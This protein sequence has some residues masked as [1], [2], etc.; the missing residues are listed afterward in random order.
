MCRPPMPISARPGASSVSNLAS[1]SPSDCRALSPGTGSTTASTNRPR[2]SRLDDV[3]AGQS[4]PGADI[5]GVDD[6]PAGLDEQ[7]II[8]RIV[9]GADDCDVEG[10]QFCCGQWLRAAARQPGVFA[11]LW[12]LGQQRVVKCDLRAAPLQAFHDGKRRAL[13]RILDILLVA[14]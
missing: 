2:G 1:R 12:Q 5:A 10:G 8:D 13:A 11:G 4:E 7:A 6:Q 14:D 9:I 3:R